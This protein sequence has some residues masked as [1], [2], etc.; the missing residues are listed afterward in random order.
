PNGSDRTGL[1]YRLQSLAAPYGTQGS[2]R[3]RLR[4]QILE[5]PHVRFIFCSC[6]ISDRLA[7]QAA[8]LAA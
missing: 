1:D 5:A 2:D 8:S 6:L 3:D 4:N 7:Y